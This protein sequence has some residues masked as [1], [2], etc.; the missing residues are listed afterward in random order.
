MEETIKTLVDYKVLLPWGVVFPRLWISVWGAWDLSWSP[1]P[2]WPSS[3]PAPHSAASSAEDAWPFCLNAP[4]HVQ[5][6]VR[7][8]HRRQVTLQ[9]NM[10]NLR[11]LWRLSQ[12]RPRYLEYFPAYIPLLSDLGQFCL[13]CN[14]LLPVHLCQPVGLLQILLQCL[15]MIDWS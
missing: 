4:A 14:A 13:Q 2:P 9:S 7:R 8:K 11:G 5:I 10:T 12:L 6:L 1:P 15:M 3:S